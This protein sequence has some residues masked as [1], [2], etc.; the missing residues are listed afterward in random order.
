MVTIP[1]LKYPRSRGLNDYSVCIPSSTL[2]QYDCTRIII[3]MIQFTSVL[4][5]ETTFAAHCNAMCA[6]IS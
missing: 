2:V 4:L 3:I 5:Y 1:I 6:F